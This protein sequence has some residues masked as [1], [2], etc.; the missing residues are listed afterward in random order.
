MT[1][2]S[3]PISPPPT[4]VPAPAGKTAPTYPDGADLLVRSAAH[5]EGFWDRH[6][7][8]ERYRVVVAPEQADATEWRVLVWLKPSSEPLHQDAGES[9]PLDRPAD[10]DFVFD[11]AHD[12]AILANHPDVVAKA[13]DLQVNAHATGAERRL[14]LWLTE[15]R[16]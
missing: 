8:V 12:A 1:D 11:T 16:P 3:L 5:D 6:P 7:A 2:A 4:D 13:E 14:R 15:A 9:A 10:L